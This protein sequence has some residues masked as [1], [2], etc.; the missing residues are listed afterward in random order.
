MKFLILILLVAG[1]KDPISTKQTDN[2]DIT[3]QLMFTHDGCKVYRFQDDG[4]KYFTNCSE[5]LWEE[6]CGKNC[7]RDVSNRTAR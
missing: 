7:R 6:S 2:K 5:T 4:N 1:C 3:V